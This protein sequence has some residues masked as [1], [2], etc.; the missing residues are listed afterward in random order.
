[1]NFRLAVLPRSLTF[2]VIVE[3]SASASTLVWLQ[4]PKTIIS[5]G[6]VTTT[7]VTKSCRDI[8]PAVLICARPTVHVGLGIVIGYALVTGGIAIYIQAIKRVDLEQGPD[9]VIHDRV[10]RPAMN[11]MASCVQLS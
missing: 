1:M 2:I 3:A 11:T 5:P 8:D 9:F 7:S 6:N 10:Y 4:I